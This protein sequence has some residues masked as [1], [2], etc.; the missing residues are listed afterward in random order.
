[1]AE[2][3]PL[4][5]ANCLSSGAG[6]VG[7]A[8]GTGRGASVREVIEASGDVVGHMPQIMI[9]PRRAGDAV[10]LVSGS[11]KATDELAWA[12]KSSD[13]ETIL[14]DAWAW[15]QSRGWEQ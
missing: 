8:Y 3:P 7:D 1:M 10:R 2:T 14:A 5:P 15:H 11:E 4:A 13:L 6:P 9:G 12:P